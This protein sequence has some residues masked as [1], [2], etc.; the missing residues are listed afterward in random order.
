MLESDV[1]K[2]G[3]M[4][5]GSKSVYFTY[6]GL[7]REGRREFRFS[8]LTGDTIIQSIADV[9]G[10]IDGVI[11]E[12]RLKRVSREGF[13]H[14]GDTPKDEEVALQIR[15]VLKKGTG[16]YTRTARITGP[17]PAVGMKIQATYAELLRNQ[18][19]HP[20]EGYITV[21]EITPVE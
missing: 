8:Y 15:Y 6:S 5:T 11:S 12:S 10:R 19:T 7:N 2:K 1:E 18:S 9:E 13:F 20:L 16:N 17:F 3:A 4:M 14:L 21:L